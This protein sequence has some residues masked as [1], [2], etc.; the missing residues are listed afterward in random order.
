MFRTMQICKFLSKISTPSKLFIYL[1]IFL[2]C[3]LRLEVS[4][5]LSVN[6]EEINDR[7]PIKMGVIFFFL[8]LGFCFFNLF[9]FFF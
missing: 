9:F 8:F 4:R 2:R 3:S 1:F 6:R 7:L 5:E